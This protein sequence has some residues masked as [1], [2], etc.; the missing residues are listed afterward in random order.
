MPYRPISTTNGYL[1][2]EVV[3]ALQKEIRR[4]NEYN[5]LYW[6]RE[7]AI[8]GYSE[9]ALK[10]M[11]IIAVEDIGLSSIWVQ[12]EVQALYTLC[13]ECNK[14]LTFLMYPYTNLVSMLCRSKKSREVCDACCTFAEVPLKNATEIDS[15]VRDADVLSLSIDPWETESALAPPSPLVGMAE[16]HMPLTP[17][18]HYLATCEW[19]ALADARKR[20]VAGEWSLL[21]F[22]L[23]LFASAYLGNYPTVHSVMRSLQETNA[24]LVAKD[25]TKGDCFLPLAQAVMMVC[26]SKQTTHVVEWAHR[27]FRASD[28]LPRLE[29]PDYAL[30]QHTSR[31]RAKGRSVIHFIEEASRIENRAVDSTQNLYHQIWTGYWVGK[32]MADR[33]P[34]Q[35]TLF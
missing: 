14:D 31:G 6:A 4:G 17:F 2:T 16:G 13:V 11:R 9:Y 24:Q 34:I 23:R 7:M 27:F 12:N 25:K 18:Q 35:E 33:P 22:E 21:F 10:R 1:L 20:S 28:E 26:R 8:S 5:A 30:D 29:V 19:Q 32:E 3:S 15:M